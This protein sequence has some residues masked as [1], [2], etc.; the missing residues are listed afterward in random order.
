M[1]WVVEYGDDMKRN[2][3]C[4][5]QWL[6]R[7]VAVVS[8]GYTCP[9]VQQNVGNVALEAGEVDLRFVCTG[10]SV[11]AIGENGINWA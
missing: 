7:E 5:R 9:D 8:L 11:K 2:E 3:D 4:Q 1:V 6:W 10:M